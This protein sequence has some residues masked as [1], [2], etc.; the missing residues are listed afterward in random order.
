M[1][2]VSLL[3]CLFSAAGR[4]ER[5]LGGVQDVAVA[6]LAIRCVEQLLSVER[7]EL[8]SLSK[9]HIG[10]L[11]HDFFELAGADVDGFD[12]GSHA[13]NIAAGVSVDSLIE[14]V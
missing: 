2:D 5:G 11:T 12:F 3:P 4:A 7:R 6:T 14:G 1:L 10:I 13:L 9:G 8:L